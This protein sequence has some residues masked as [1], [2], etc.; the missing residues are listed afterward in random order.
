M[1]SLKANSQQNEQKEIRTLKRGDSFG[2]LALLFK[3]SRTGTVIAQEK[4]V[5]I[6][7][8]RDI[9]KKH[10]HEIREEHLERIANLFK[11]VPAL[12]C[13]S[14]DQIVQLAGKSQLILYASN[15]VLVEE[16]D[17]SRFV[18]FVSYGQV[19]L[20]QKLYYKEKDLR[21]TS[22]K[23][24]NQTFDDPSEEDIHLGKARCETVEVGQVGKG[25]MVCEEAFFCRTKIPYTAKTVLPSELVRI[26]LYDLGNILNCE[27]EKEISSYVKKL[28]KRTNLRKEIFERKRWEQF[29]RKIT[30]DVISQ[31]KNKEK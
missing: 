6:V 22:Q 19:R 15:T 26:S 10:V 5:T 13:L 2:D 18:Y 30:I 21:F 4:L 9:F 28:P 8:G 12:E 29:K 20:L 31:K 1:Y 7:I 17:E 14:E 25:G 11:E 27:K 23:N 16:E 3:I 24:I